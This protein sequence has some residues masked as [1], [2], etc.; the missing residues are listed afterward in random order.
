MLELVIPHR[1]R[2]DRAPQTRRH[3]DAYP[4]NH[5]AH[6]DIPQHALLAIARGE[7]EDDG[8][9]CDDEHAGVGE[10]AGREEQFLEDG[11]LADGLFLRAY[12]WSGDRASERVARSRVA[13]ASTH[14]SMQ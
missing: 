11:Y 3:T 10:E 6:K 4:A 12:A 5:T 2:H 9:G 13:Q 1:R 7:V 8:E 14:R